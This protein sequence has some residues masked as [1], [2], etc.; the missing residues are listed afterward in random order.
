VSLGYLM[1]K[2]GDSAVQ[3]GLGVRV[4]QVETDDDGDGTVHFLTGVQGITTDIGTVR[5]ISF[6]VDAF[7]HGHNCKTQME[8]THQDVDIDGGSAS[9][10]TNYLFRIGFQLEI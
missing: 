1:P 10:R 7:Y 4:N 8:V 5:E 2:N 3:W 9:D 6:V